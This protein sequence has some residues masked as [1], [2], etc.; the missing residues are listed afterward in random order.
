MLVNIVMN[1]IFII[2]VRNSDF[3]GMMFFGM[4]I[5]IVEEV[6]IVSIVGYMVFVDLVY[7]L[8]DLII[9]FFNE[10]LVVLGIVN[11]RLIVF[12]EYFYVLFYKVSVRGLSLIFINNELKSLLNN[13]F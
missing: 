9:F 2:E 7:F 13:V 1:K 12:L 5:V 10:D 3:G 11:G 8:E 4:F 6:Y